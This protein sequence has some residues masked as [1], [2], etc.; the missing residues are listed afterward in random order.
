MVFIPLGG[1]LRLASAHRGAQA[2]HNGAPAAQNGASA[3]RRGTRKN[4]QNPIS[5]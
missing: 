1:L 4:R 2:A 5:I 3:V